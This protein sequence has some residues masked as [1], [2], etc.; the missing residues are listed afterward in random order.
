MLE[1]AKEL[2]LIIFSL[3]KMVIFSSQRSIIFSMLNIIILFPVTKE[4]RLMSLAMKIWH[5]K[6]TKKHNSYLYV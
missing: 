3:L 2:K 4:L 1:L 6:I 5:A